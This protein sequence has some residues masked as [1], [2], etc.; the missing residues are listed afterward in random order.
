M[1]LEQPAQVVAHVELSG[2]RGC[3]RSPHTDSRAKDDATRVSAV[4]SLSATSRRTSKAD[5]SA[6]NGA[7]A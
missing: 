6:A 7:P 5:G 2:G 4:G 3:A 1:E